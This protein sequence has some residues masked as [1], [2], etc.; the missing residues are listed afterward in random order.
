MKKRILHLE[1]EKYSVKDLNF[2]KNKFELDCRENLSQSELEEITKTN[3]YDVIFTKLG[4]QLNK[5]IIENQNSLSY[6][7][8][9]T[10]GLNHIDTSF[11]DSKNIKII[12]LKDEKDFLNEVRSTAEHTWAILLSLIRNINYAAFDVKNGNW[13][14]EP[15]LASELDGKTIGIVGFGRLGKMVVNFSMAFNMNVLAN[16]IDESVF[17]SNN[18]HNLTNSPL[19]DILKKSDIISLHIPSNKINNQFIN[20]NKIK[21]MKKGVIIIN[22]SRGEIIDEKALVKYLINKKV[23]A[24]ATDVLTNDSIWE[25]K[26]DPNNLIYKYS[27]SNSNVLITPHMGG[28]GKSSIIKTRNFITNKFI[29]SFK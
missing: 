1:P 25:K 27:L 4:L 18:P 22:T 14:R 13:Q 3:K 7:V 10:T 11:C 12:S 5:I 19:S 24:L 17:E 8:T 6:I 23:S 20:E 15:F 2:L 26:V 21:L 16:D 29:N 28:Y 9:P